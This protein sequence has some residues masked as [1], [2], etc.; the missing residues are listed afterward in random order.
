MR[1]RIGFITL[2]LG[3]LFS[4][5]IYYN[6]FVTA[7][8]T[9]NIT[10]AVNGKLVT[11]PDQKPYINQDNRTLVPVR[12][13]MEAA[14]A[15]VSWNDK[16]R[17][18][19]VTKGD[20][21]AVFT[22][23]SK[24]YTINGKAMQMDTTAQIVGGSRTVFPLRFVAEAIGLTVEWNA[25]TNTVV[26]T[27]TTTEVQPGTTP[28]QP[29]NKNPLPPHEARKP[30]TSLTPEAKARLMAYPYPAGVEV[31]SKMVELK[32]EGAVKGLSENHLQETINSWLGQKSL[33][34]ANQKFFFDSDLCFCVSGNFN[35]RVRGVLQTKNPDGSV[36]EQDVEF[37]F[38]YGT[39]FVSEGETPQ[40][41]H[42]LEGNDFITLSPP[43]KL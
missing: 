13:P 12:A 14:G 15:T 38:A 33:I 1:K 2:T 30:M 29:E 10:V 41:S 37:G 8:P 21:T 9:P 23:G 32:E 43:V 25:Q 26:I 36:I 5:L 39:H 20:K 11:F 16:T 34:K 19:T 4:G 18:V 3:I 28:T 40:P 22:I 17:Q 35:N 42:L 24:V 27:S 31:W 6:G 7:A